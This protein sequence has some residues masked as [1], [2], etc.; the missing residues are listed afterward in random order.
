MV[1]KTS[2]ESIQNMK[3][4]KRKVIQILNLFGDG[5]HRKRVVT[6][7]FYFDTLSDLENCE[8]HLNYTD[9]K[10]DY[11]DLK[12]R[13]CRDQLLLIVYKKEVIN[14]DKLY[15]YFVE[16]TAIAELYNGCYDGYETKI[17]NRQQLN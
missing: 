16:L 1:N 12:F 17:E 14:E 13:D 11:K 8:A 10:T 6:Q 9:F 4:L 2:S 7:W 3:R 15:S 5:F